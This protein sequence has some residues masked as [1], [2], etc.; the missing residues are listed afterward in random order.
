MNNVLDYI[1]IARSSRDPL[2]RN[3][4]FLALTNM[5]NA[6]CGFFFWMIAARLYSVEEVGLATA[7]ISAL[8]LI[9]AFSRLGFNITIIRFF[10]MSDKATIFGTGLFIT[11]IASLLMALIFVLLVEYLSPPLVFMKEPCYVL[12]FLFVVIVNSVTTITGTVFVA[13]R[14]ADSYLLQNV[15]LALK[16]PFLIPLTFLGAVGIFSSMGL[17]FLVAAFFGLI[18]IRR[19]ISIIRPLMDM[20]FIRKSFTYSSW[21]YVSDVLSI[22]PTML[23]TIMV[24]DMLGE[25][26]AARYYIVF[27][28]GNIL[29]IIPQSFASS[30]FVEGSH[31]EG[32]KKSVM[33]AGGASLAL[34]VPAVL[35]VFFFGDRL[36]GFIR[37]EYVE[38]VG[39]L[40]VIALSS[41]LV[42]IHKIFISIQRIRMEIVCLVVLNAV[43]CV[44]LLG[45]SYT[46]IRQYGVIGVGYGWMVTYGIVAVV[47][48]L[49]AKW[50]KWI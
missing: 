38:A 13:D 32:L 10:S 26:E 9:I 4:F 20:N 18:V 42:S 30:L 37:W 41:F 11:T 36:L 7:L 14:K 48:G 43:M 15:L 40:R 22:A 12:I 25:A 27:A 34:L 49:I 23:L 3:S 6:G 39:L 5:F 47:I 50:E 33:Q 44:L 35:I 2:Y 17:A 46:F 21:N 19:N 28:I 1:A 31:G 29:G 45:L 16:I 24:L 8:G